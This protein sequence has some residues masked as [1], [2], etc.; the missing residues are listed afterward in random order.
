MNT[1]LIKVLLQVNKCVMSSCQKEVMNLL[2]ENKYRCNLI[3]LVHARTDLIK[4]P[5]GSYYFQNN[6]L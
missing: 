6:Y 4:L 2:H 3:Y 1:T 5:F